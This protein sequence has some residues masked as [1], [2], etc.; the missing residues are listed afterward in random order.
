M[1][2]KDLYFTG[3]LKLSLSAKSTIV[4]VLLIGPFAPPKSMPF[5]LLLKTNSLISSLF[6]HKP[7]HLHAP[8][9]L[10]YFKCLYLKFSVFSSAS[11]IK[12]KSLLLYFSI[13]SS[14]ADEL[15]NSLLSSFFLFFLK[16]LL[17]TGLLYQSL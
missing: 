7:F 6:C 8:N 5:K 14:Y 15:I 17:A 3:R 13:N 12:L 1:L 10:W 4:I 11:F 9:I 16:Y 2:L